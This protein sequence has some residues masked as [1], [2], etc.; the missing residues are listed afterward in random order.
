M[1]QSQAWVLAACGPGKDQPGALRVFQLDRATGTLTLAHEFTRELGCPLFLAP[2]RSG[3]RIFVADFTEKF[4]DLRCGTLSSYAFDRKTGRVSLHNRV[5]S[6][7]AVPCYVTLSNDERFLLCA[8]Y[9]DGSVSVAPVSHE[10]TLADVQ[11]Y[12]K[13][14]AADPKTQA[15][16][17]SIVL[18]HANRYAIAADLGSD[19]LFVYRFDQVSGTLTPHEPAFVATPAKAGPRHLAFHPNGRILYC[20]TEYDNT[21]LAYDFDPQTGTLTQRQRISS[22][23]AG[24]AEK[25]FGA[26]IH[27]HRRAQVLW[28]SNRGHDSLL[29]VR[30]DAD[31]NMTP[32]E[33]VPTGGSFPREVLLD[34]AADLLLV[35]NEK[36]HHIASYVLDPQTGGL[37]RR[38][39]S[40]CP[41][42]AGL[43]LVEMA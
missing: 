13:H 11:Q 32:G 36:A 25:T 15:R 35:G 21:I 43:A 28:V 29:S 37:T 34:E 19:R 27:V 12:V 24:Y 40:A 41:A 26:D 30:L 2:N 4:G 22:L 39:E 1:T 18:D 42:P 17:H 3:T 16:A 10:G 31:G 33:H 23:P 7:G 6:M 20:Q 5:A 38:V 14:Q 9:G 8:S